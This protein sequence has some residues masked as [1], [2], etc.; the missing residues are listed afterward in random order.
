MARVILI[1]IALS[2]L[3]AACAGPANLLPHSLHY[4][5]GRGVEAQVW[6][7]E[8]DGFT[9]VQITSEEAGVDEFAVSPADGSIA[10][11]SNNQLFLLNG[12]GENRRLIAD[13]S[14]VDK[15]AED[16]MFRGF[17]SSP[18]FSPDGRTL[19]YGFDGLHLYDVASGEDEH[20]LTNLGNLL[21]ETFVFAK[22]NY[23]PGPWS[24]DGSML[25]ILMGY[26]EG[27]TLAVMDRAEAQPFRRLWSDGPVCCL[28]NWTADGRSVL[29][30][31]PNYTGDLPGLWSYDAE[32]GEKTVLVGGPAE[33]RSNGF[34]G[35]PQQLTSGELVYFHANLDQFSPDV[36]IPLVMVSSPPDGSKLDQVRP[37]KFHVIE[38]LWAPDGSLALVLQ[39]GDGDDRQVL[40][41]R[42]D[43]SP[44]Q[45]LIEEEG[46]RHLAWGP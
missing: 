17:L 3:L 35:W 5:I 46:L 14:E 19:A 27:S 39:P 40:L 31:N 6:R 11:V 9:R 36:G 25:L 21:G 29:V 42:T 33:D 34:V 4:S 8:A 1:A 44:L 38:A 43:G 26:V 23:S 20:V 32:T 22:E 10:F 13:G 7:L 24:P 15:E 30:A 2:S 12:D 45:V 41:A 16:Y 28:F 18:V 37:E